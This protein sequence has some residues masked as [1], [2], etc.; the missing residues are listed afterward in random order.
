M[1]KGHR[2]GAVPIDPRRPPALAPC[3]HDARPGWAKAALRA[4]PRPTTALL[5]CTTLPGRKTHRAMPGRSDLAHPDWSQQFD[6]PIPL[7]NGEPL[8]TLRQAGEYI[9]ALSTKDKHQPHWQ[10]AAGISL[11]AAEGRGPVMFARIALRG[12]AFLLLLPLWRRFFCRLR[13]RM[14]LNKVIRDSLEY[15]TGKRRIRHDARQNHRS[16][17]LGENADRR[18][19]LHCPVFTRHDAREQLDIVPDDTSEKRSKHWIVVPRVCRKCREAA[20]LPRIIAMV[21]RDI[22][23]RA[24]RRHLWCGARQ[25]SAP[26]TEA[27][28]YPRSR[29]PDAAKKRVHKRRYGR[30]RF[31]AYRGRRLSER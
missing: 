10:T 5:P 21:V 9:A 3:D 6:D 11:M 28:G 7:P 20:P 13:R 4:L 19:P 14:T 23:R 15:F 17:H 2:M 31:A 29:R 18:R 24:R 25:D 1:L 22:G 8:T 26:Y 12:N 27:L 16:D 30:L